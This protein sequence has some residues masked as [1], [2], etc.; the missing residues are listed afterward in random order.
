VRITERNCAAHLWH[1][2]AMYMRETASWCE[3]RY[4]QL[5]ESGVGLN[6][7]PQPAEAATAVAVTVPSGA[8]VDPFGGSAAAAPTDADPADAVTSTVK[9]PAV[10]SSPAQASGRAAALPVTPADADSADR[11]HEAVL[12]DADRTIANFPNLA[13]G[14]GTSVGPVVA[15][16]SISAEQGTGFLPSG[17][18]ASS[19]QAPRAELQLL[20]THFAVLCAGRRERLLNERAHVSQRS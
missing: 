16:N 11:P 2:V 18:G 14:G 12:V 20:I 6:S 1:V 7:A 8:T 9:A 17:T 15:E 3:A 10:T 19:E 13:V 4:R 5:Q